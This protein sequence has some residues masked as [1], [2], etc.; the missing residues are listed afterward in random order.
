MTSVK[1][2]SLFASISSFVKEGLAVLHQVIVEIADDS[3][4]KYF[5]VYKCQTPTYVKELFHPFKV[6]IKC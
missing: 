3:R 5:K 4:D 2:L 1:P 6:L